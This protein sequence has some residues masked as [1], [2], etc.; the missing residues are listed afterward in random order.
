MKYF[1][2]DESKTTAPTAS[3]VYAIISPVYNVVE[4]CRQL[5]QFTEEYLVFFTVYYKDLPIPLKAIKGLLSKI[6]RA[7]IGRNVIG[8]VL[9]EQLFYHLVAPVFLH[10]YF[11]FLE[12]LD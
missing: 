2:V 3:Q 11:D 9:G 8:E 1:L 7:L 4:L 12:H 5:L 10:A 6:V